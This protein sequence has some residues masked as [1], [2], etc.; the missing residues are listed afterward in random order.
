M[1]NQK[2]H[3]SLFPEFKRVLV[4]LI[5]FVPLFSGCRRDEP[6]TWNVQAAGP[7][8]YGRIELD[9]LVEDS[10]LSAD[11]NNLWH[12]MVQRRLTDFDL[13]SLVEIPDTTIHQ[14]F[15]VPLN[16]G[17]FTIPAGITLI[18]IAEDKQFEL[19]EVEL[20][21]A[22]AKSGFLEYSVKSYVN[23][24]LNCTYELPGLQFNGVG[25]LINVQ[26]APSDGLVPSVASGIID[27]SEYAIDLTGSTGFSRNALASSLVVSTALDAP[28]PAVVFGDDSVVVDLRFIEPKLRYARGYFGQHNYTVNETATISTGF[29]VPIGFIALDEV[30]IRFRLENYTGVDAQIT[31]SQIGSQNS[32][33]GNQVDLVQPQLFQTMNVTRAQDN[34]GVVVPVVEER[35]V[36]SSNSNINA[37]LENLPN[38]F[39]LQG[40]VEV[41]PLGDISD[42][43]DFIYTAKSIEA[44]IELDLPL[45]V[46]M[47]NLV[48]KDTLEVSFNSNV[49]ASG[50]LFLRVDN[51]FP[52]GADIDARLLK[53]NGEEYSILVNHGWIESAIPT[54]DP[55]NP[56]GVLSVIRIPVV[57]SDLEHLRA[58]GRIALRLELNTPGYPNTVGIY[59][60][61]YMD[62][63]LVTH[64]GVEVSV[65]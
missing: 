37:F 62:I 53:P 14:S 58:G 38:G 49:N 8:A 32:V 34:N 56:V 29:G 31:F 36:N 17:P 5:A 63:H 43:N 6:T 39:F 50:A 22:I 23:G 11:E 57:E 61:H 40:D 25:T 46:G 48:L 10:L 24:Y 42:G 47:N 54:T 7:L 27:L 55:A 3:F 35:V 64:L 18:S 30:E 59:T 28:G 13:D 2:N 1:M 15:E 9:D 21:T 4:G 33:T 65:R 19:T 45:S 60:T 20:K 12:L 26:T 16:G 41:N 51:H 44:L 52:V